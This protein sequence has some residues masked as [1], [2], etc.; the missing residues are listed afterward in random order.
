MHRKHSAHQNYE[1]TTDNKVSLDT[2]NVDPEHDKSLLLMLDRKNITKIAKDL[3]SQN[4]NIE[5]GIIERNKVIV[6]VPLTKK[7]KTQRKI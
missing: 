1:P 2:L 5:L 6:Q 7:N 4:I 3:S